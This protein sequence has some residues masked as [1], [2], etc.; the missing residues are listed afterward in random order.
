MTAGKRRPPAPR[1]RPLDGR[2]AVC[3]LP[4]RYDVGAALAASAAG[5]FFSLT[6][7]PTET[8]IVCREEEAPEGAEV[9]G[10]WRLIEVEGPLAFDTIGVV[11][12]LAEPLAAA[13][14]SIFV[15]STYDTDYLMVKEDRW[16][17]ARTSLE[18]AGF[19]WF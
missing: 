7:T 16:P 17:A 19:G 9:E 12:A 2:F 18:A 8:S 13:A 11:A 15:T 1:L 3:R 14:V 4:P 6:R 10:G 5:G